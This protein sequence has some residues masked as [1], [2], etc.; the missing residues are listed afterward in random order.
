MKK[1]K[2][3]HI[4]FDIIDQPPEISNLGYVASYYRAESIEG[5]KKL[6]NDFE[7]VNLKCKRKKNF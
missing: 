3:W 4:S 5:I 6:F 1:P 2:K 7:V